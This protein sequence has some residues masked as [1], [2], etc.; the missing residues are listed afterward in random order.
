MTMMGFGE[1][2]L[3]CGR[4][5]SLGVANALHVH[6]DT[7]GA[8]IVAQ[9]VDEVAP[10]D[11]QHGADGDEGAE[12]DVFLEAPV[13]DGGTECAALADEAHVAGPRHALG[14]RGV[15]ARERAHD[16]EAVGADDAHLCAAGDLQDL[17]FQLGAFFADFLETC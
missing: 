4:H 9:V 2:D 11:V 10:V 8:I 17:L 5:E 7:A 12:A 6:D 15:E 3:A 1:R 14:E 16:A 13:Q